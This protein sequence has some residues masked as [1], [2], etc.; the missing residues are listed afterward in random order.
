FI[1]MPEIEIGDAFTSPIVGIVSYDFGNYRIQPIEKLVYE[2]NNLLEELTKT[3]LPELNERQIS[4][5][6]YNVKNLSHSESISRLSEIA[7]QIV[8]ELRMPDILVLQEVM[9][10]DGLLDSGKSSA[11]ENLEALT[12]EI[13]GLGGVEY[14]WFNIDP[15][16]N[17]DGGVDG[18]NIRVVILFR[19]D[20]GVKFL[21]ALPGVASEEVSLLGE[22]QDLHLSLSPGLIWPGN[23]AFIQSRKPIIAQFQFMEQSFF[24]IGVHF[25][26]KGPDG[27]LFGDEQPPDLASETQRIAQAK[28]VNGFVKDILELD[29]QAFI[30]VAGDM[31]DF[32]WTEAIQTLKSDQLENLTDSIDGNQGFTYIY[33]GNGQIF[34]QIFV[35]K[36]M[37]KKVKELHVLN[38]NSVLPANDQVSDHDPV[39]AI[40][41]FGTYE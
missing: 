41:D 16:N 3:N 36:P 15:E 5:A 1:A 13:L 2:S 25:N 21:S 30:I 17:Q 28:A 26:S 4:V 27:P 11:A 32:P 23:S 10:D 9:D 35:S 31:N 12:S 8:E 22:G 40:F 38:I 14:R 7:R 29:P 37:S 39:V 34:D 19:M 6:T 33:E 20:R 24:V 18:G